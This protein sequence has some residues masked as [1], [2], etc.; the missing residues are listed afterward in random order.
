MAQTATMTPRQLVM[1]R[2]QALST[3]GKAALREQAAQAAPA[4]VTAP[5]GGQVLHGQAASK[6]RRAALIA[7]KAGIQSKDRTRG[8]DA[9]N[10]S[11]D[12][13]N[14]AADDARG[15]KGCGCGCDGRRRACKTALA[16]AGAAP[17]THTQ[18]GTAAAQV[19]AAAAK[20]QAPIMTTSNVAAYM[21]VARKASLARREAMSTG[22]K[23]S[24]QGITYETAASS[25]AVAPAIDANTQSSNPNAGRDIARALRA[26][27]SLNGAAG[28]EPSRPCGRRRPGAA[29]QAPW[30]VGA[31]ETTHGQ[32]VTGTMTG[33]SQ[34]V[35]GDEASTCRPITGTEYTGA[36]MTREFCEAQ[37]APAP[38]KVE[39][40]TTSVGNPVSGNKMGRSS[41]MTGNEPGSCNRVTGNQYIGSGE[42]H[43]FCGEPVASSF[44]DKVTSSSQTR[45][46]KKLSGD[47]V[48]R[49]AKVTGD[50][51]GAER[52]PTGTQYAAPGSTGAPNKVGMSVT[53]RGGGVTGTMVGRGSRVTGDEPGSCKDVTGDDYIGQEQYSGFCKAVPRPTDYKSGVSVTPTGGYI[54]GTMTGRSMRVTGDEPG[55]C[56]TVSGT[57][58]A[59]ADQYET[60]CDPETA[61]LASARRRRLVGTPGLNMTGLQPG[62]GGV[63]TG[64]TAGACQNL[65]GTPYVG[66]DQYAQACPDIASAEGRGESPWNRFSVQP[67]SGGAQH[68]GVTGSRYESGRITGSFGKGEGKL[69]GTEE[70]RFDRQAAASEPVAMTQQI[71]GRVVPRISGEGQDTGLTI[72]GDDWDRNEHVT[73]TEGLSATRR[74]QTRRDGD[75]TVMAVSQKRNERMTTPTSRVT[76]GSGN[77]EKGSLITYS[78]GAR[79]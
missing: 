21:P 65:S 64:A 77:T 49:S 79:G 71:Q 10:V 25:T 7:G 34:S 73:G 44:A 31:S 57:P 68:G 28:Q 67:P 58:Y 60:F 6:A 18:M 69:T 22:G 42:A 72:T 52:D 30:K 8:G 16:E 46:G 9:V 2:R 35:T 11:A 36:E 24:L 12:V 55:S 45:K 38:S 13:A 66:G 40:N 1:A 75:M 17:L 19:I 74:N 33:R 43:T 39:V 62:I 47:K 32:T 27:R 20:A 70:A 61:A 53:L 26:R 15:K 4:P 56:K 5:A 48:G 76:G 59:G 41:N 14:G 23:A 37:P 3:T 29:E 63:M 54:T 78:G 51:Q 50:E